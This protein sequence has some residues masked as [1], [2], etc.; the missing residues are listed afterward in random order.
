MR[1][2]FGKSLVRAALFALVIVAGI[3]AG[4]VLECVEAV[5]VI[6]APLFT[7]RR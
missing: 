2:T 5:A 4:V 7:R 3:F 6:L 1:N